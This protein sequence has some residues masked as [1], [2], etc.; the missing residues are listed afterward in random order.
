VNNFDLYQ[1]SFEL[2][3]SELKTLL[4]EFQL[5]S[6]VFGVVKLYQVFGQYASINTITTSFEY[7]YNQG[8]LF[9]VLSVLNDGGFL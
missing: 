8:V 6:C 1:N 7:F 4:D 9:N 3:E 2:I 5:G